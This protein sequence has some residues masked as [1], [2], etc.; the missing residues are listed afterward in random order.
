[1]SYFF[2][3]KGDSIIVIIFF[4]VLLIRKIKNI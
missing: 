3:F 4:D 1:M 2:G